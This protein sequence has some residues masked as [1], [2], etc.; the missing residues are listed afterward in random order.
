M[1][2]V[3][4]V[5]DAGGSGVPPLIA[6]L[7]EEI[8][9]SILATASEGGFGVIATTCKFWRSLVECGTLTS[10]RA[11]HARRHAFIVSVGGC[12]RR[13]GLSTH[14]P[15]GLAYMN[16]N[17]AEKMFDC[18]TLCLRLRLD[19]LDRLGN[20]AP[21]T[22]GV[23]RIGRMSMC[24]L[25]TGEGRAYSGVALIGPDELNCWSLAARANGDL[26]PASCT[27]VNRPLLRWA[28]SGGGRYE[29]AEQRARA[30]LRWCR[31]TRHA[32]HAYQEADADRGDAHVQDG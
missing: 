30:P 13:D 29:G 6:R 19:R 23:D 22:K 28:P 16:M 20:V 4:T 5:D 1:E 27:K 21:I 17:P 7:L 14:T 8:L 24:D 32:A 25:P 2:R 11:R 18:T 15:P 3:Y 26:G 31:A 12:G 10:E 9:V